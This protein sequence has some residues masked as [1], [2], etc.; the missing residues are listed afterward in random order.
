[1]TQ[2]LFHPPND[3][4][5]ASLSDSTISGFQHITLQLLDLRRF[6]FCLKVNYGVFFHGIN[7]PKKANNEL[8]ECLVLHVWSDDAYFTLGR[9]YMHISVLAL[10]L[11]LVWITFRTLCLHWTREILVG[12]VSRFPGYGSREG[13]WCVCHSSRI[14]PTMTGCVC[15]SQSDGFL[16]VHRMIILC[17]N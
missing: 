1:M 2:I 11:I 9:V 17:S 10:G 16:K 5:A 15:K 7:K 4:D 8:I 13:S 6:F 12:L 3:C 14:T